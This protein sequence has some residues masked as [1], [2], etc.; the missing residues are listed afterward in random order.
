ML[1]KSDTDH[2]DD[3]LSRRS[4]DIL[5]M[6]LD[7][8]KLSHYYYYNTNNYEHF[9]LE[10]LE[11]LPLASSILEKIIDEGSR[12]LY[13]KYIDTKMDK[14]LLKTTDELINC[15]CDIEFQDHD[16][17]QIGEETLTEE[18]EPVKYQTYI[19]FNGFRVLIAP[20]LG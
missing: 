9:L 10:S 5:F 12:I 2:A 3:D 17:I 8:K 1:H 19:I 20:I 13:N 16:D 7:Y 15:L 6:D 14:F 18:K 11:A 4:D